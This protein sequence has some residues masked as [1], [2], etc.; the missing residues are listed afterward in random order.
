MNSPV[1]DSAA[2]RLVRLG[3]ALISD[4]LDEAGFHANVI[5]NAIGP[6]G[7]RK[8][9]CGPATC[10][11]GIAK[12][13]TSTSPAPAAML[14]TYQ[15]PSF[16][17]HGHVLVLD[18]GNFYGGAVVGSMLLR[19]IAACGVV[20]IVTD[21]LV[22]DVEDIP[23]SGLPLAAAGATPLNSARR[24]S[25]IE[26]NCVAI[27]PAQ[28]GGTVRIT[29]LDLVVGDADGIVVVPSEH[30]EAIAD[31]A[32]EVARRE[33]LLNKTVVDANPA[34]VARARAQR[35]SDTTWLRGK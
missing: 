28:G 20:A 8:P 12:V 33:S 24:W 7:S 9:F 11:R 3:T 22:R 30:A 14:P 13:V 4:I 31:M 5:S 15:L 17:K 23:R 2:S 35:F 26:E 1:A 27:M 34:G 10:V 19:D 21:G 25:I 16:V 6:Y 18:T 29:P 32:E